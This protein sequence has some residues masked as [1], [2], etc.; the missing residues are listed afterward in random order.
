MTT[1]TTSQSAGSG[2]SA[3]SD[4][5]AISG[6]SPGTTYYLNGE[7]T[8]TGG[9]TAGAILSFTTPAVIDFERMNSRIRHDR[10]RAA[11]VVSRGRSRQR[12]FRYSLQSR[13]ARGR[14]VLGGGHVWSCRPEQ[15][16]FRHDRQ[17]RPAQV[18]EFGGSPA[19]AQFSG[20]GAMRRRL[21]I[22]S[23]LTTTAP[24]VDDRLPQRSNWTINVGTGKKAKKSV[25]LQLQF[26]GPVTGAGV[27]S[28]YVLE[29][30]RSK[31][32][33]T[34]YT[35]GAPEIRRV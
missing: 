10:L 2:T 9:T 24:L 20:P 25:V 8:S 23:S 1:S 27:L 30:A 33:K 6:L 34:T 4:A 19:L 14:S 31:K 15:D 18:G 11:R 29:S 22:W 28:D 21:P 32:G 16:C 7:A 17:R 26:S 13:W 5:V 12:T 35:A 3:L